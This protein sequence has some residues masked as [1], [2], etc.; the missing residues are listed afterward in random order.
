MDSFAFEHGIPS[1]FVFSLA[2]VSNKSYHSS[3]V[4]LDNEP[5]AVDVY[6]Q[7][8]TSLGDIVITGDNGLA[9][10]MLQ[11]GAV[12]VSPRGT[13][14]REQDMDVLFIGRYEGIKAKRKKTRIKGPPPMTKTDR[15]TFVQALKELYG[16]HK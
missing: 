1:Y 4:V 15:L 2:H 6:I 16:K 9:A 14:F 13:I 10:M 11:K 7:N 5:E 12:P 3:P 8:H